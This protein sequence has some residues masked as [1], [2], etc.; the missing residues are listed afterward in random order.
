MIP[1]EKKVYPG[2]VKLAFDGRAMQTFHRDRRPV[3]VKIKVHRRE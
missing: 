1:G 2:T 3:W